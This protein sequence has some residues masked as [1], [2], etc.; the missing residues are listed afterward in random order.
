[1]RDRRINCV[2]GDVALYSKVVIALGILRESA[3]LYFHLV[4]GLPRA[5]DHFT[6][7]AHRL[8]VTRNHAEHTQI[9]EDVFSRNSFRPDPALGERNVFRHEWIQM[10]TDHQHVQ[11]L[12]Y[13]VNGEGPCRIG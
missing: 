11:V 2:F 4:C 8:R 13:S 6:D 5:R 9:V 3:P 7:A 12:G 1:M 10:M